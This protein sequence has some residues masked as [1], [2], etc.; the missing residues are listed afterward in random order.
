MLPVHRFMSAAALALVCAS[1]FASTS[2]YTSSASFM[3]HVAAGA[4][5]ETFDGINDLPLGPVDFSGAGFSYTVASP[6]D[7]Y[8]SGEFLSTS[9]NNQELTITFTSGNVTAVGSNFYATDSQDAF[10]AVSLTLTLSDGTTTTFTPTSVTDSFRGFSSDLTITSLV[11]SAP[12]AALYAGID[13]LTV[14][15]AAVPEPSSWALMGL[16][17]VGLLAARRR[18]Q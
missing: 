9:S 3:G 18:A 10:Q 5:T 12:G 11:V 15:V 8:A 17:L 6:F 7:L 4:Y 2:T 16:G 14:G 1:S 13:N